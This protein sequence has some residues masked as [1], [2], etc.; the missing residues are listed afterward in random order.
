MTPRQTE[1][2]MIKRASKLSHTIGE[3]LFND[4]QEAHHMGLLW[5]VSLNFYDIKN[6]KYFRFQC[7]FLRPSNRP[8]NPLRVWNGYDVDFE[9]DGKGHK[10]KNDN[11][12]DLLK[13][14]DGLK[15]IHIPDEIVVPKF[16]D[17]LDQELG[18]ALMGS[19]M[20]VHIA[21]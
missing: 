11:W 1:K 18:K 21:A 13:N 3:C 14:Q 17:Y 7:D 12:K 16:W 9:I 4:F 19:E 20:V 8:E 10:C 15:V 6:L 2:L 5:D